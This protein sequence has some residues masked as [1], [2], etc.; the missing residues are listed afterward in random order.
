MI[1]RLSTTKNFARVTL[2]FFLASFLIS[3]PLWNTERLFPNFPAFEFLKDLSFINSYSAY[4]IFGLTI[5]GIIFP[6]RKVIAVYILTIVFSLLLDQMRIQPW[7]YFYILCILPF[8]LKS[9]WN[10]QKKYLQLIFVG[11]YI[12]SGFHKMNPNFT[13]LI[14]E[15]ILVDGLKI[16]S[17]EIISFAK[18]F[19]FI[20]PILEILCGILFLFKPTRSKAV[21]LGL[22]G[23]VFILYYLLFGMKGNWVV[24]PWNLFLAFGIVLLFFKETKSIR[25]PQSIVKKLT[26]MISLVLLPIG[27]FLGYVDHSLSFGLYDGKLKSA[28]ILNYD[29]DSKYK[30]HQDLIEKGSVFDMGKW[31]FEELQVPFYPE[32]RFIDAIL[33]NQKH[34]TL[35]ITESPLWKRNI[36]GTYRIP[37]ENLE[38]IQTK[39]ID[40]LKFKDSIYIGGYEL[41]FK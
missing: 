31:S 30:I 8:A 6:N 41:I 1:Y 13:S 27:Y 29:K 5:L 26:L 38:F 3:F 39:Q 40:Q 10:E 21:Y 34:A 2:A 18:H 37:K 16:Q 15:S 23:H 33:V 28:Y 14:F 7:V 24:V 19:S 25:I 12:W 35:L 9:S 20:V 4:F 32:E 17:I 36:L 11:L 22:L